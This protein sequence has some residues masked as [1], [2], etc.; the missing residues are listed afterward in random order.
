MIKVIGFTK[1]KEGLTLEQFE[2]YWHEEHAPLGFKILPKDIE[3]TRYVQHYAIPLE[4]LGDPP[5]DGVAEFCFDNIDMFQKW[6]A[7]FMSDGGQPL[8]NDEGNFMDSSSV[9]VTIVEERVIIPDDEA[10]GDRIKLIAGVKRKS[11]LTLN[12]FK[13]Y[14]YEKHAPL[15]LRVLPK[16][17]FV[18]KYVHNYAIP[19]EGFGEQPFDGIGELCFD[20]MDAFLK[21]TEWFMGEG[22]QVLRDDEENF[23]DPSTRVA[24]IARQ[25]VILP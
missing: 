16:T 6:L 23:V 1:K 22:G 14:W 24:V 7:W 17:P 2:R 21:S 5:F 25:R 8:R 20:D 3:F 10:R 13:N 9:L 4:G 11:G 15:A 12:E 19:M 18:K